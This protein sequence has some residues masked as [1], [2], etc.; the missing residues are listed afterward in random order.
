MKTVPAKKGNVTKPFNIAS[1]ALPT[2]MAVQHTG[3]DVGDRSH[4]HIKAP[5]AV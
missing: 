2:H 5:V 3:P 4:P 1:Y